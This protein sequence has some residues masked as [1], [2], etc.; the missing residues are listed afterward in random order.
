M[1]YTGTT[2]MTQ[3]L[4]APPAGDIVREMVAEAEDTIGRLSG[5]ARGSYADTP[6][7]GKLAEVVA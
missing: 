2:A 7:K 4:F 3:P 6:R 1:P 5:I